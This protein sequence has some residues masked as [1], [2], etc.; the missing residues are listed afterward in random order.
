MERRNN[1]PLFD[2][3]NSE[4][5][6]TLE[7]W[8]ESPYSSATAG[9]INTLIQLT[10]SAGYG[11]TLEVDKKSWETKKAAEKLPDLR[12]QMDG[13]AVV[14][15]IDPTKKTGKGE[16]Y[17]Y[18]HV[19]NPINPLDEYSAS[20]A[21]FVIIGSGGKKVDFAPQEVLMMDAGEIPENLRRI[22]ERTRKANESESE[23]E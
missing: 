7:Q 9:K 22:V 13:N 20:Y 17:L 8:H 19:D 16:T 18:A 15:K 12:Y 5:A 2:T 3:I 14:I 21:Y 6:K 1:E 10:Q 23:P 11:I 4:M